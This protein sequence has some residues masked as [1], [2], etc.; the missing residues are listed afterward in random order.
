MSVS[1]ESKRPLF[2][3]TE[4]GKQ[5]EIKRKEAEEKAKKVIALKQLPSCDRVILTKNTTK[6]NMEQ[7]A[8]NAESELFY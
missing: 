6:L 7:K 3:Q 4:E 1:Q 5:R 2:T 8:R